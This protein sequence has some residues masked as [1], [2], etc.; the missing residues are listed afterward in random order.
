M[1]YG[2]FCLLQEKIID[3]LEKKHRKNLDLNTNIQNRK[4]F[5]NPRW[6]GGEMLI[7]IGMI[8]WFV[9]EVHEDLGMTSPVWTSSNAGLEIK[10]ILRSPFGNQLEKYSRQM[11]IFSRQFVYV[12]DAAH[13]QGFWYFAPSQSRKIHKNTQNSVETLSNTCLYNIFETFLS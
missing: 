6:A 1:E 5:R 3:L 2:F 13:S 7:D 4:D 9:N 11:Q 12:N 8:C 10:K